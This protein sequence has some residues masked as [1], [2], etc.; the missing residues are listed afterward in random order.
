MSISPLFFPPALSSAASDPTS[1]V[2]STSATASSTPAAS[3]SPEEDAYLALELNYRQR[4]LPSHRQHYDMWIKQKNLYEELRTDYLAIL[5]RS[6]QAPRDMVELDPSFPPPPSR[7]ML[8]PSTH[9]L[10]SK[11]LRSTLTA[12]RGGPLRSSS[13]NP[14]WKQSGRES[15]SQRRTP[16]SSRLPSSSCLKNGLQLIRPVFVP[17]CALRSLRETISRSQGSWSRR[18]G[19]PAS[20]AR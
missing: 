4:R 2:F 18:R 14:S 8:A 20:L 12:V 19:R 16:V 3:I 10:T 1:A 7:T 11:R 17:I 5:E 6:V 9:R 15:S 13:S